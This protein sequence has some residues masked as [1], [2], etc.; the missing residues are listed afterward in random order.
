APPS[1][2]EPSRSG[3]YPAFTPSFQNYGCLQTVR[4]RSASGCGS[5]C[6]LRLRSLVSAGNNPGQRVL[7]GLVERRDVLRNPRG[8]QVAV[9]DDFL[10][11][12]V[13]ARVLDVVADLVDAGYSAALEDLGRDQKLRAVAD[14][15]N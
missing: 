1:P 13:R 4:S 5:F 11:N 9:N 7:D 3:R 10:V 8:N 14:R 15:R 2:S 12:V 6:G